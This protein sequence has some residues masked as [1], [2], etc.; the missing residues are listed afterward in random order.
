VP[1]STTAVTDHRRGLLGLVWLCR[2][3]GPR[4][5]LAVSSAV[6]AD[7]AGIALMGAATWLLVRAAQRPELAAL[8]LGIV[9]VRAAAMTR[10]LARYAERL[11]GHDAALGA[12]A[13][14]R[15]RVY[16]ALAARS[17][18]EPHSASALG[19]AV[20][21][22]DAVQDLVV[23][24]VVPFAGALL[25]S[26]T[27]TAVVWW[28]VPAAGPLLAGGLFVALALTPAVA[29]LRS[30]RSD[31]LIA[32]DRAA[33]TAR[34]IDL[35]RGAAELVVTG[36]GAVARADVATAASRLTHRQRSAPA[37]GATATI[38][39]V[40]GCTAV[41]ALALGV[42]ANSTTGGRIASVVLT[43]VV[44]AAFEVCG[45]LPAAARQVAR[46]A[47]SVR[48]IQALT[49]TRPVPP[50]PALTL[51][52]GPPEIR[53]TQLVVRYPEADTPALAD[54]DL[55]LPPGRRVAVVGASGSG[56]ST[57]LAAVARF[58]EPTSGHV[59][60]G[61]TDL[62]AWPESQ[63]R[64]TVGGV[65]ADAHV[66]HDTIAANLRIGQPDAT[67]SDLVAVAARIRLGPWIESL[68]DGW[69][70]VLGEDAALASGGQRRRLLLA[71]ALLA[72]PPVLL[73]DEP[74]EGL[75]AETADAV[76]ADLLSA[77]TGHTVLLVTH[78][79]AGLAGFDEVVLL[80]GG[81]IRQRGP[82][83]EL[84]AR[85]GPYRDMW[86]VREVVG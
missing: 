32:A 46:I 16:R 34:V 6:V 42:T 47:G 36:T 4:A 83:R 63:L 12:L 39:A 66:F 68:P 37:L 84:A 64:G 15:D 41:G 1:Q 65:L 26:C 7:L 70:T 67:D 22:V 2:L 45:P 51:S 40:A 62:A 18:T 73:L 69:H 25:V 49:D 72:R 54:I 82:H 10:G 31:R 59:T 5:L 33:L 85:P 61:G 24:C 48:R 21:D 11:T 23:R 17:S 75:D 35:F 29:G 30:R 86:R 52:A 71:R 9:G 8:S 56:K 60:F 3:V 27:S 78:R 58:V 57:L 13:G 53:L 28:L 19:A 79:L 20:H 77:T 14:L 81:R 44:L 38:L 50:R 80:D 76:L 43:L 55:R 74:T